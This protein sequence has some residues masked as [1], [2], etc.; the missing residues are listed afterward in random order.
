MLKTIVIVGIGGFI[1]T[2]LRFLV[3]RL[4]QENSLSLFPWA[5]F[6]VNMAGCLLI[7]IVFGLSEKG[8]LLSPQWRLFL[9]VGI[10]GGF[11]TFSSFSNDAYML[12]LDKEWLRVTLY[13]TLS[14]FLGLIAVYFGR[15]IAKLI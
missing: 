8:S 3:S 5:T 11:T 13:A 15:I 9:T 4:V 14:L 12:L 10:C 1:G 2:V 6:L 7:G